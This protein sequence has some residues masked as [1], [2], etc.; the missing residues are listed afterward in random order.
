MK[1]TLKIAAR[2]FAVALL[3]MPMASFAQTENDD[4]PDLDVAR[5][6]VERTVGLP[7]SPD[8]AMTMGLEKATG[9]PIDEGSAVEAIAKEL[10]GVP[11]EVAGGAGIFFTPSTTA[12]EWQD[13]PYLWEQKAKQDQ[14]AAQAYQFYLNHQAELRQ[15]YHDSLVN[16]KPRPTVPQVEACGPAACK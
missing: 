1:T 4:V 5:A 6:V 3:A 16:L 2:I 11:G 8:S 9:I 7:T 13:S 10:L 15:A 12:S 14:E